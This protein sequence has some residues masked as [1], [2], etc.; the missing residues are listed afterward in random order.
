ME[1]QVVEPDMDR[2]LT[3]LR[4]M[5]YDLLIPDNDGS[6]ISA[7]QSMGVSLSRS[8]KKDG[9][10][11]IQI[12]NVDYKVNTVAVQLLRKIDDLRDIPT[13]SSQ[14]IDVT[15]KIEEDSS[16]AL[17]R[18]LKALAEQGY[19]LSDVVDRARKTY[20]SVIIPLNRGKSQTAIAKIIG[21]SQPFL[22]TLLSQYKLKTL[23]KV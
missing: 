12:Q 14:V 20:L 18:G 9:V 21:V 11:V 8:I 3:E 19:M 23:F 13:K 7:V 17:D 6:D 15:E 1:L 22:S 10:N 4:G 5:V 16:E 2:H